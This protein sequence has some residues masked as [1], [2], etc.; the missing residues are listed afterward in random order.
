MDLCFV[1]DVMRLPVIFA[2]IAG[3]AAATEPD[4]VDVLKRLTTQ[5]LASGRRVPNYTCVETVT[6]KYYQTAAAQIPRSC[7]V[8]LA[9]RVHPTLDRVLAL[10]MTD[11][12][13]LDV[14][15]TKHGEV[16]SW[17]GASRFESGIERVVSNGPIGSG[18]FGAFLES[19]F[20]GDAKAFIFRHELERNG[21]RLFEYTFR[22]RLE[23]SHYKVK[24]VDG[25][26][27]WAVTAYDGTFDA[28]PETGN[29]VQLRV[30]T[31]TLPEAAGSCNST[32]TL[33]YAIGRIGE[34]DFLL[35]KE[36]VQRWVQPDGGEIENHTTFANCREYRG[37]STVSYDGEAPADVAV[38][39]IRVKGETHVPEGLPLV[40]ELTTP[41][42][43]ETAAAGDRFIGRLTEPLR[44]SHGKALAAK[45]APVQGR[46]LRVE[47]V[48]R[49]PGAVV[50]VLRPDTVEM[51]S[52]KALVTARR[53][54]RRAV[55]RNRRVAVEMPLPG[56][57]GAG[58]FRFTGERAVMKAGFRSEWLTTR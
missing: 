14:T 44:D 50:M 25:E 16:Y 9:Q 1:W 40:F 47:T 2:A 29:L 19:I 41:I 33:D 24:L 28:D 31:A 38:S 56:E 32:T 26:N 22:V 48:H 45:G 8:A 46:I 39:G 17:V 6:R 7:E 11:R 49:A 3:L 20:A 37:E 54:W 35:P 23:D 51:R 27:S 30:E 4:P 42:D 36:A 53:D 13:R 21:R 10:H 55:A 12:L 18:A 34:A 15:L 43:S 5:V 57:E 52:G 58:V